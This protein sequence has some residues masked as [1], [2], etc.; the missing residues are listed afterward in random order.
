MNTKYHIVCLLVVRVT[1]LPNFLFMLINHLVWGLRLNLS[2]ICRVVSALE[3]Q[4][5]S[6][7]LLVPETISL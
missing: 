3:G 2:L 7:E 5:D 4:P 6:P 1:S